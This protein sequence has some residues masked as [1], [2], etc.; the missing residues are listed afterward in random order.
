VRRLAFG[1]FRELALAARF[2]LRE[3]LVFQESRGGES[4]DQV[5][6]ELADLQIASYADQQ[7]AQVQVRLVAV[8]TA[9][10]L[11]E[12]WGNN[13][14]RIGVTIGV[15]HEQAWPVGHRRGDHVQGVSETR[16]WSS[17]VSS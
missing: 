16:Q 7:G 14:H 1:R 17:Q 13:Q 2:H 4:L 10:A 15:A 11:D 8:E 6:L 5:L 9:K 3:R 12:R